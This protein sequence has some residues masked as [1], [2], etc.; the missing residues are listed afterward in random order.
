MAKR[1]MNNAG[2]K[3]RELM[4]ALAKESPDERNSLDDEVDAARLLAD[5]AVQMYDVAVIRGHGDPE[6][7]VVACN[8]LKSALS[9]VRDIVVAS[10]K[11]RST[12]KAMVDVGA[13][14]YVV[15]QI[16]SVIEQ[17]LRDK[18]PVLA[19]IIVERIKNLALPKE[20]EKDI[21]LRLRE[22][23]ESMDESVPGSN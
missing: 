4:L 23:I 20:N 13:I 16:T 18:Y 9:H 11:V 5:Q 14:D 6:T 12:N 7:Q 22:V 21:A 15:T 1:Y 2:P 8:V 17:E 3:L 19:D 10:S